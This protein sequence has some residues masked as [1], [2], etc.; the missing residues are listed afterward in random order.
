MVTRKPGFE[1]QE[2][3]PASTHSSQDE[4]PA[5]QSNGCKPVERC[6]NFGET[7]ARPRRVMAYSFPGWG[8]C[9]VSDWNRV[10][11]VAVCRL[12]RRKG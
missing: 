6:L 10:L 3:R 11:R 5:S 2:H 9:H 8:E 4:G 1:K 12:S 7:V